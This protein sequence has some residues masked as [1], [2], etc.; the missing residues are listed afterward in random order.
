MEPEN[1]KEAWYNNDMEE[2][3]KWQTAIKKE[4]N[5][6]LTKGVWEYKEKKDITKDRRL[7]GSKLVIKVKKDGTSL[8]KIG[9]TGIQSNFRS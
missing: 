3:V 7:I 2:Q 5:N 8:G 4:I 6:M 1:F 9:C